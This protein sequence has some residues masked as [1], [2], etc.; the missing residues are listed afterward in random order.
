M[1]LTQPPTPAIML[2]ETCVDRTTMAPD[3]GWDMQPTEDSPVIFL[4][5]GLKFKHL[6]AAMEV[7]C[8]ANSPWDCREDRY[9]PTC[10]DQQDQDHEVQIDVC[11][12]MDAGSIV[13]S[14]KRRAGGEVYEI[15]D[16]G[17]MGAWKAALDAQYGQYWW[18]CE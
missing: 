4:P 13:R 15:Q 5:S 12:W 11:T 3:V 16:E 18:K 10:K 7:F 1:Y 14:H 8:G 17:N 2:R 6:F 9:P